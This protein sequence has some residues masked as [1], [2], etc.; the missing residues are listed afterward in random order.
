MWKYIFMAFFFSA[1]AVAQ[2]ESNSPTPFP[3]KDAAEIA[4]VFLG[5]EESDNLKACFHEGIMNHIKKN[6]RY[7]DEALAKNIQGKVYVSF[8][9]DTQ[10]YV[11]DIKV[12]GPHVILETEAKRIISKLPRM[13]EPGKL[14]ELPVVYNYSVP[15]TFKMS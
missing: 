2:Q 9:I 1:T 8:I 15:I 4:P 12:R 5:C 11:Q 14:G 6:F 3:E 13:V 10:G 7:P